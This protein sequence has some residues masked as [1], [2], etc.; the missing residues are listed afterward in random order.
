MPDA[1][2]WKTEFDT[3]LRSR[4]YDRVIDLFSLRRVERFKVLRYLL[5]FR[6]C[7]ELNILELGTG[8]GV[9]TEILLNHYQNANVCTVE[10][11]QKMLEKAKI[12]KFFKENCERIQVVHADYS[13]PSWKVGFDLPFGLIITFDS[14]HHL[15]HERKKE[16]YREIYGLLQEEGI[17]VISDHVT[18][19][20]QFFE[21]Q[22]FVL[23]LEEI[24]DNLKKVG[25][26]TD[27]SQALESISHWSYDNIQ[28]LSLDSL[29][30]SFTKN[31]EREGDNPMPI[32]DHVEVMRD[33]GFVNVTVEYRFANYAIISANK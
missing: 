27:I 2:K 10:G 32:M 18:S 12:K 21:D 29:R 31:L 1:D 15:T 30:E 11:A 24:Y 9:L 23:W 20:G 17:F 6:F 5:P 22:Q 4:T 14:L 3:E 7:D 19:K 28:Q 33:I 26:G 13:T 8:T 25:K 16:L